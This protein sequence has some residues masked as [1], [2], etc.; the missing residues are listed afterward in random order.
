[1]KEYCTFGKPIYL[2]TNHALSK[3][4]CA[5]AERWRSLVV[6]I[7]GGCMV[8]AGGVTWSQKKIEAVFLCVLTVQLL[9]YTLH[10]TTLFHIH[11]CLLRIIINI[12]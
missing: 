10:I 7:I 1:M 11:P 9:M 6:T 12:P 2:A 4:L 8:I 3:Y 5:E